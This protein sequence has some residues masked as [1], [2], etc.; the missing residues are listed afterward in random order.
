MPGQIGL[1]SSGF[2]HA[3]TS[4]AQTFF[5]CPLQLVLDLPTQT[6]EAPFFFHFLAQPKGSLQPRLVLG[7]GQLNYSILSDLSI[8]CVPFV[9]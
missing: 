5:F 7:P 1:H 8:Q 4:A 9:Y 6:S 2:H 3:T